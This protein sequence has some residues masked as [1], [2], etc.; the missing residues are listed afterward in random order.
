MALLNNTS[1][2]GIDM[3]INQATGGEPPPKPPKQGNKT[4]PKQ[5]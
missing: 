4:K 5:K 3:F 1:Q 2:K